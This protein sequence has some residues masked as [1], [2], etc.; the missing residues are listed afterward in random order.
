MLNAIRTKEFVEEKRYRDGIST[1]LFRD[2]DG[3]SLQV[4]WK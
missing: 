1:F 3:R 2:K 4:L